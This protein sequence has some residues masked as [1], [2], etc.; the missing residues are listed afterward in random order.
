[1]PELIDDVNVSSEL[2]TLQSGVV[3]E[4]RG[5]NYFMEG[6]VNL[7]PAQL[8]ALDETGTIFLN[9]PE[10]IKPE[11][12]LHPV[13]NLP[14]EL[15]TEGVTT[16]A[17]GIY[18][19]PYNLW[20]MV[21]FVYNANLTNSQISRIS[22][23]LHNIESLTNVRFYNATGQ[24]TVDPTYGFDYPY[25]DFVPIGNSD[26]SSSYVGR[27]GGRQQ[28]SLANFAFEPW[29]TNVIEHEIGHAIGML[30]EQCRYDRD[31]YITINWSNLTSSG[32]NQFSKRT[33]NYAIIGSYDF[34]SLMGYSSYTTS[35]SI[36]NNINQPM[37]TKIDGSEIFQGSTFSNLDRM[38]VNSLYVP[39]I[40]RSDV[41]QELATTVYKS[42]NTVMTAT[43]R[44]QLQA[45]LNNGNPT[46]PAN[47]RIPNNF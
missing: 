47:G 21:R 17:T 40:A 39:Y 2:V 12:S 18:P 9:T 36:V 29:N 15:Y 14:L 45:E 11:T 42:D 24:P 35:S 4:K 34:N 3:V 8:I 27:I 25:L 20:A 32:Q 6:D 13:Y 26:V 5:D 41:Y 7:S 23:A 30:H 31:S 37:Y 28:V 46:P 19:T 10:S 33:T 22:T 16:R 44:L 43:E 38:W 1:M